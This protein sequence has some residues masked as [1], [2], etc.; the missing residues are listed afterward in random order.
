MGEEVFSP[1][2][3]ELPINAAATPPED[4]QDRFEPPMNLFSTQGFISDEDGASC[5][6]DN[7]YFSHILSFYIGIRDEIAPAVASFVSFSDTEFN[8]NTKVE[9][10]LTNDCVKL[11]SEI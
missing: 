9:H 8:S 1:G 6:L 2:N 5:T 10:V 3:Q 4:L 7:S 11:T